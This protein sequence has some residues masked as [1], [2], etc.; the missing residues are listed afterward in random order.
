MISGSAETLYKILNLVYT[1]SLK[2]G[3][4]DSSLQQLR[5]MSIN[6][7]KFAEIAKEQAKPDD[8]WLYD[9]GNDYLNQAEQEARKRAYPVAAELYIAATFLFEKARLAWAPAK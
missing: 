1:M 4:E 8:T 6:A 2:G 9:W 7:R 3:N 5:S